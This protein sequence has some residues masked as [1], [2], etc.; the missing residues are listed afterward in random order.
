VEQDELV[1]SAIENA[2]RSKAG[3]PAEVARDIAFHMTDWLPD[4]ARYSAFVDAPDSLSP[5]QVDDLIG[6]F[7]VHVP[8]HLAAAAKLWGQPIY[9]V[10][11]IGALDD[12]AHPE[13][14][15]AA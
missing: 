13:A 7:L 8:N 9:D 4:L 1:V 3:L 5:H 10:F 2:M 11:E 14:P 15:P 6:A 12:T